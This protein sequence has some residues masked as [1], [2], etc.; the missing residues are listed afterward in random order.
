MLFIFLGVFRFL[1]VSKWP[2]QACKKCCQS[3]VKSGE[4]HGNAAN[5]CHVTRAQDSANI[6]GKVNMKRTMEML[7]LVGLMDNKC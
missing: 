7:V 1:Y 5:K 4:S 6:G 2:M 3:A